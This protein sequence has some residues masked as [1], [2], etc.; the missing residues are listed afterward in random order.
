MNSKEW[1]K[2]L[3]WFSFAVATVIVYKTIDSVVEIFAWIKGF[4]NLLM[5]FL[6]AMLAAYI[7]YIPCRRIEESFKKS[8]IKPL[9]R[10]IF[11][12]IY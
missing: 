4:I 12:M 9:K 6:M 3:F 5:P 8:R 2:W 1:R 11:Y 10:H 7:L